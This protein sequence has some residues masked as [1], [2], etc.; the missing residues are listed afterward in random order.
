VNTTAIIFPTG[1]QLKEMRVIGSGSKE[2]AI[3]NISDLH[4]E[5]YSSVVMDGADDNYN[6][7]L[8]N[9]RGLYSNLIFSNDN[10]H[11]NISFLHMTFNNK[12]STTSLTGVSNG[13]SFHFDNASG[14]LI[15]NEEPIQ[16]Y[17]R[18]PVVNINNGIT[19]FK[20]FN[21]DQI[22]G[23]DLR[24]YGNTSLSVFMSDMY[25]FLNHISISSTSQSPLAVSPYNEITSLS[26]HFSLQKL[27]SLPEFVRLL[28]LIPFLIAFIFLLYIKPK[29]VGSVPT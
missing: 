24:V 25:T 2:T 14:A 19:S 16:V 15:T 11:R 9:G 8:T 17:T 29:K 22:S 4:I 7:S 5:G 3:A 1:T 23:K 10:N 6:V 18:E 20:E 12:R 28:L 21:F 26:M 13:R 27:Y